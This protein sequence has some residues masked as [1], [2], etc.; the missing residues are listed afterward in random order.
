MKS[1]IIYKYLTAISA[2]FISA[3][4]ALFVEKLFHFNEGGETNYYTAFIDNFFLVSLVEEFAKFFFVMIFTLIVK[5]RK[6]LLYWGI[7]IGLGFSIFEE[8]KYIMEGYI[9]DS[10]LII[11]FFFHI[12]LCMIQMH[13]LTQIRF[14]RINKYFY[15]NLSWI[16]T[17]LIHG[18]YDMSLTLGFDLAWI[19]IYTAIA[20]YSLYILFKKE[21]TDVVVDANIIDETEKDENDFG[22]FR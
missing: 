3:W 10:K 8:G 4:L 17:W 19:L 14:D 12:F 5:D 1:T 9:Y 20:L 13:I 2:G 11:P 7:C 18:F 22:F 16:A 21:K 15:L 6:K